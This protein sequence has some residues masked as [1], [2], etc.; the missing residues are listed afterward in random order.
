MQTYA[1][2][3]NGVVSNVVM[4]DGGADWTPDVGVTP[5]LVT[6]ATGM[7]SAGYTYANGVFAAPAAPVAVLS[8][9]DA[10][11]VQ[12]AALTVAYSA[13]IQVSVSYMGTT[14]QADNGSQ[15]RLTESLVAGTVPAGFYWLDANNVQVE[16]T[17]V[18]LQGLASVMLVR[19]QVEFTKLQGYKTEVRAATSVAAVKAV[20]WA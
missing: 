12:M 14:F 13:A 10:Q 7:A 16:M 2:V 6:A 19:G 20:T 4:W 15:D 3:E 17:F 18:Q 1:L 5:V 8:L 9:A 11:A